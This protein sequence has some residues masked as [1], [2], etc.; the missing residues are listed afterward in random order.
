VF[1]PVAWGQRRVD[2]IGVGATGSKVA[3]SVAKLGVKNLH[4]WDGD[5][6]ESGNLANQVYAQGHV[7]QPKVAALTLVVNEATG[8]TVTP[9]D[10]WKG[11][12]GLG[13]VVFMMAD[14][15]RT[16]KELY[17]AIRMNPNTRMVVDS[18]MG[19]DQAQ[20]YSYRP[21]RR[22]DLEF[23]ESTL[24]DDDAAEV[25]VSACGTSISVGPTSDIISGMAVWSLIRLAN[26]GDFY[27]ALT[28][29][30]RNPMTE[31]I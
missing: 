16:R 7:G 31:V 11:E 20:L 28:L 14:S 10:F 12:R 6:V 23:Y 26:D 19:S 8:L 18:R 17:Q 2:V 5:K 30:A 4:V 21:G 25:E 24:F 27:P 3:L 9:H 29:G 13:D 22:E 1:D 15:M